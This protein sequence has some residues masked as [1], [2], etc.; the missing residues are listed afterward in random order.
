MTRHDS[1][2][3]TLWNT[4]LIAVILCASLVFSY[5]FTF[6]RQVPELFSV[7]VTGVYVADILFN[8]NLAVRDRLTVLDQRPQVVARYLRGWFVVDFLAALPLA[9]LLGMASRLGSDGPGWRTVVAV[10]GLTPLL[11]L[12]K[13]PHLLGRLRERL[14]LH[15][16]GMR[17]LAFG[18]WLVQAAHF[19]ALGWILIGAGQP[20]LTP[21]NQYLRALY[22]CITT[23]ATIGYGDYVPD[24]DSNAQ[25]IYAMGVEVLG[26]GM[27]GYVVGNVSSLIVNR[28]VAKARFLKKMEEVNAFLQAKQL[29]PAIQ[30]R[31]RDYYYYLW[32]TRKSLATGSLLEEMPHTLSLDIL[33]HLNR[34]ILEKVPLFQNA[35]ET[36]I[37][38]VVQRLEPMAFLP[39]DYIIRQG[40]YGDCMY[41]LNSGQVEVLVN[42]HPIAQLGAGSP[43][44]ET[45]LL[46]GEKRMASV[47]TLSYC[48]AYRLAK[49]DFDRLRAKHP[50]FDAQVKRVVEERMAD[51]RRKTKPGP[52]APAGENQ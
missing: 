40:E 16:G 30:E 42:H 46:Q 35:D 31:V 5:A 19:M 48:E 32:T 1:H 41:F 43:F 10:A 52:A 33:L 7:L 49:E 3:Q 23:I 24:H 34:G 50:V 28:D 26:V 14:V 2:L 4:F 47:R 21:A 12:L 51:T 27:F 17:L 11:K 36:F 25:L 18:F 37:R 20:G 8:C 29:P 6:G 38:E 44:G 15:P 22:W 45:A 39:G 9:G 13:A